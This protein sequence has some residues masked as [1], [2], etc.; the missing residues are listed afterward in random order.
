VKSVMVVSTLTTFTIMV[1]TII[2]M[3]TAIT[4]MVN[5]IYHNERR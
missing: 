1:T 2:I 4:I 5:T 3:V